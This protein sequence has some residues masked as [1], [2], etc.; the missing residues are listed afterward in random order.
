MYPCYAKDAIFK[1]SQ[2]FLKLFFATYQ[3]KKF[4]FLGESAKQDKTVCTCTLIWLYTAHNECVVA[5]SRI[6]LKIHAAILPVF[7][8]SD[9]VSWHD[10]SYPVSEAWFS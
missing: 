2:S 5:S 10:F 4:L 7:W 8:S 6:W 1:R 9:E 3:L